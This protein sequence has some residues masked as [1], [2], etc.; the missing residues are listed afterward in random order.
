MGDGRSAVA[1]YRLERV[2]SIY[3]T[4]TVR[5]ASR[6]HHDGSHGCFFSH[7]SDARTVLFHTLKRADTHARTHARTSLKCRFAIRTSPCAVNPHSVGLKI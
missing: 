3:T 4:T 2:A 5:E 7:V 1:S 6:K